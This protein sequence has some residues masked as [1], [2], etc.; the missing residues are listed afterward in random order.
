MRLTSWNINGL[1]SFKAGVKII[2][3][4]LDSDIVCIQETKASRSTLEESWV[5]VEGYSSF[6]TFPRRLSGYSG[7]ATFCKD[8]FRPLAAEEGLSGL[9]TPVECHD[10]LGYYGNNSDV[11]EK[12]LRSIDGEGRALLTLHEIR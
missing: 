11:D 5:L 8:A 10:A 9:W 2:L 12:H 6:F 1:R 7:V 3:E 4:E